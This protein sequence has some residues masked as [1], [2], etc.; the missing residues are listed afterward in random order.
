ML[1]VLAAVTLLSAAASAQMLTANGV[2][3]Q[4]KSHV[5]VPWRTPTVDTFKA[6]DPSAPVTGIAVTMMATYDVLVRAAARGDNLIITHEPTFYSHLDKTDAFEKA[7]DPVWQ[8]KENFIRGHHLVVWR[9]HDHWH[10]HRPDG[11]LTGVVND[12]NWQSYQSKTEPELFN[13]PPT[14]LA[15]LASEIKQRLGITV[16][17]VVGDPSLKVATVALSPGAGGPQLHLKTLY[18]DHPDVLAI[19]EVPEWETI[20]YIADASAEGRRQALILLG[21]IPSEQAGMEY[22][23][24]WLKTFI[25]GVKIEFVPAKEFFWLAK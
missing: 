20:E 5:G 9:F 11:I 18:R 23:A 2:I 21:H 10:M 7:N 22:C 6:G 25:R 1:R 24:E 12:L 16:V 13:I 4:I 17:R 14:T 8:Q 15:A 19:G 3:E